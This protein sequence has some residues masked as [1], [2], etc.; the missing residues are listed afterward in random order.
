VNPAFSTSASL[1]EQCADAV[2][3][4]R[5]HAWIDNDCV[6]TRLQRDGREVLNLSSFQSRIRYVSEIVILPPLLESML[7]R[8]RSVGNTRGVLF[9]QD[10]SET[11]FED[12]LVNDKKIWIVS[13]RE[14]K[15]NAKQL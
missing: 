7:R 1:S 12:D 8:S 6:A 9:Q 5:D 14:E 13:R 15:M 10:I 4:R 3:T 2:Q 11:V